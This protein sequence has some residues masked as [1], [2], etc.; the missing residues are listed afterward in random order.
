MSNIP[1]EALQSVSCFFALFQFLPF[2]RSGY[3][4]QQGAIEESGSVDEDEAQCQLRHRAACPSVRGIN[5]R[6]TDGQN[7]QLAIGPMRGLSVT[8][9]PQH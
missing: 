7:L 4:Q 6:Q 8:G 2:R 1:R 5:I 9:S 3:R